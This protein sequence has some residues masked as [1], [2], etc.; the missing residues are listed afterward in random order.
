[1]ELSQHK[2]KVVLSHWDPKYHM[3]I[4]WYKDKQH[5][6]GRGRRK[7][8]GTAQLH[9]GSRSKVKCQFPVYQSPFKVGDLP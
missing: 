9:L 7:A 4:I 3:K 5:R 1:M 8:Q 6:V 2:R